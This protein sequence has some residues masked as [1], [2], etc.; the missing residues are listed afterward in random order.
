MLR[1]SS[2][3]TFIDKIVR[4]QRQILESGFMGC[5][6]SFVPYSRHISCI[7]SVGKEIGDIKRRLDDVSANR[8]DFGVGDISGCGSMPRGDIWKEKRARVAEEA[9][10]V[11]LEDDAKMLA[12]W[13]FDGEARR[14][15]VSITVMGGIAAF[16]EREKGSRVLLTTL[17]EEIAKHADVKSMPHKMPKTLPRN[18]GSCPSNLEE[19]GRKIV[20]KC[21]GLPLAVA[22][23]G[24]V[25]SR[26]EKS[27]TEWDRVLKSTEW[28]LNESEDQISRRREELDV[29]EDYIEQLADRSMI[30]AAK[31]NGNATV[32]RCCIHD[33]LRDLAISKAKE[34]RFLDRYGNREQAPSNMVRRL[35]VT[36][37]G[38]GKYISLNHS[39]LHLRPFLCISAERETLGK[40]QLKLHSG[41]F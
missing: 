23:L 31:R 11:G 15:V 37:H 6:G 1:T 39:T 34:E 3:P 20:A 5:L 8:S 12:H 2:T 36:S 26:K 22:E 28:W 16:P 27:V 21:G 30:Q 25:L 7:H 38:I 18:L 9:D 13:L 10:V 17:N 24:G 33:L 19:L 14:A 40:N 32:E 41:D 35:V 4:H 29:A